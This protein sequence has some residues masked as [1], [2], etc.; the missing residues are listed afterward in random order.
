MFS[1]SIADDCVEICGNVDNWIPKV[2]KLMKYVLF[3]KHWTLLIITIFMYTNHFMIVHDTLD[4]WVSLFVNCEF[5]ADVCFWLSN[6]E[7]FEAFKHLTK[8]LTCTKVF[9]CSCS[10]HFYIYKKNSSLGKIIIIF[11]LFLRYLSFASA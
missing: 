11:F 6:S 10:P 7:P 9:Y 8:A 5:T 2:C 1:Q 4:I 3:M